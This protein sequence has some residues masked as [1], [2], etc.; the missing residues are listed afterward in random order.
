MRESG[1]VGGLH[2]LSVWIMRLGMIN[3]LWFLSNL[4]IMIISF[5][6][7]FAEDMGVVLVLCLLLF[8]LAPIMLFP[9][10]AALFSSVREWLVMKEDQPPLF[11]GFIRFYKENYKKSFVAG[12]IMSLLWMIWLVDY[13]YF[14]QKNVILF[15]V[16]LMMG[17]MLFVVTINYFSVNAH[18]NMTVLGTLKN[19][20]ILTVGRPILTVIIV[21]SSLLIGYTSLVKVP[22][23]I[24]F[25]SMSL[26]AFISF[27]SFYSYYLKVKQAL[28]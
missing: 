14:S 19:A 23:L 12:C 22:P 16:F 13:Y 6:L 25:F 10:T 8:I 11:S 15:M 20:L 1:I 24:P 28:S 2:Y 21:L 27:S 26:I 3:I 4:P 5:I 9:S 17:I 7:L 18:Y